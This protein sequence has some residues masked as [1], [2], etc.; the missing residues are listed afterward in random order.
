MTVEDI[1]VRLDDGRAGREMHRFISIIYW[2]CRP[3]DRQR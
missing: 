2:K 3:R 1:K